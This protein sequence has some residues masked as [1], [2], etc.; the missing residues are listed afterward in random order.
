MWGAPEPGRLGLSVLAVD[1]GTVRIGLAWSDPLGIVLPL[2]VLPNEGDEAVIEALAALVASH[3]IKTLLIGLPFH[4]DGRESPMVVSL[5]AL[6]ARLS[7]RLDGVEVLG[8]DERLTSWD[9][10]KSQLAQGIKP[11]EKANKGRIDTRA[12][13]LLL[14][15]YLAESDPSRLMLPEPPEPEPDPDPRGGRHRGRGRGRN[16]RR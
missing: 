11:W 16:R 13:S 10:E 9:A 6:M 14:E 15:D 5:R 4:M 2:P 7:E 1:Y 3:G 12:A 8:R